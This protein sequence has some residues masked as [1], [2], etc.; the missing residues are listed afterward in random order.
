MR[1]VIIG[2][3]KVGYTL[4]E[5]LAAEGHDLVVIDNNPKTL[6]VL[7]D[8]LDVIT[9]LGNGASSAVQKEAGVEHSDLLIAV[10]SMDEINMICCLVG[11]KLGVKHTIARVRNPD[12]LAQLVLLKE[13]L[14]LS[15]VVNP[16]LSAAEEIARLL[17]YP[18]AL[19]I[20][21]FARGHAELVEYRIPAGSLLDSIPLKRMYQVLKAHVLV[22]AVQ[23]DDDVFIPAGDF[24]LRAGDHIHFT[25]PPAELAGF[26]RKLNIPY[27]RVR[28]VIAIGGGR[29][30]HYLARAMMDVGA[31]MKIVEKDPARALALSEALP[32]ALIIQG[33]GT[34][35][36]LLT[37][38]GLESADA[39]VALTGIDEE[40]IIMSL[41]AKARMREGKVITKVDRL[42]F[43]GMLGG[44]GLESLIAPKTI[45]ANAIVS[46]VRGMQNSLGSNV[47][48]L[49]PML[50]GKIEVLE[51]RIR[52]GADYLGRP[53]RDLPIK[54]NLLIGCI[55]RRN[56][57][58]IPDGNA[59]IELYD[60]VIVI[61]EQGS[62]NDFNDIYRTRER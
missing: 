41:Y 21:R 8:A 40:N 17:R 19:K 49:Y 60:S 34:D 20:E 56:T 9:V 35:P 28:D 36:N 15:M 53:L 47:E 13:E 22:C 10:T 24:V 46:F 33:D 25:T 29:I 32:N 52:Q 4:T 27:H 59:T 1:I 58:I 6:T 51:F 26:F 54:P 31:Q 50:H 5:R 62:M 11:K 48:A 23:R 39:F 14:G 37:E 45:T 57:P 43:I 2:D 38:E 61:S 7:S 42:P 30:A 44:L 16:E 55:V 12:Y 18:S 3:G